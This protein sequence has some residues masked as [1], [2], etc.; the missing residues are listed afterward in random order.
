MDINILKENLIIFDTCIYIIQQET[1]EMKF[2]V[3]H[4][5]KIKPNKDSLTQYRAKPDKVRSFKYSD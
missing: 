1:E 5:R 2:L 3:K 4:F